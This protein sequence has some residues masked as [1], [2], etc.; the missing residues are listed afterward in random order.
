MFKTLKFIFFH[1]LNRGNKLKG[2][3][4]FIKW[5][6]NCMINP[7]PIIYQFTTN[8]KL[9]ISKGM[10]GATG[11][12]YTGLLEFKDM[13][14]LL[15]FLT[16]DDLFVDVGANVG[17]Y[18]ILASAEKG[19]R[20]ISVEPIHQTYLRL[21]DNIRINGINDKV[22]F[23]NIGIG[24]EDGFLGFTSNLDTVNHV[25]SLDNKKAVQVVVR[26]LDSIIEADFPSLIKIDVEGFETEVINGAEEILNNEKLKAIIIEL[27][28]AGKRYGY[29]EALIHNKLCNYGFFPYDY[30][31]FKRVLSKLET[32]GTHNTIY[33]RDL[34]YVKRRL[35]S[36][37]TIGIGDNFKAI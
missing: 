20:T 17:V 4:R 15:H 23:L 22:S 29:D 28:G 2:I 36:S 6:I 14:F 3:T 12:L 19:S 37:D 35:D 13:G 8:S 18:T 34:E 11:N 32:Y 27:N 9:I 30:D 7:F 24:S 1:P 26:K 25:I 31:P 5:Q 21:K 16:E 10:T 33:L